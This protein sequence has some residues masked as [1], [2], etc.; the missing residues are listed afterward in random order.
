VVVEQTHDPAA[1]A[2][3]E[4]V[5]VAGTPPEDAAEQVFQAL[6]AQPAVG[7]A[8]LDADLRYVLVNARLAQLNGIP[9]EAHPGRTL[10]EVVPALAEAASAAFR[11]VLRTGRPMPELAFTAVLPAGATVE[12]HWLESAY[13]VRD[14]SG[15]PVAVAVL[16]WEVTDRVEA[17]RQRAQMLALLDL[18]ILRAP[19]G[20]ALLDRDLRYVR[21]NDN[22]AAANGLPVEA[23]LGRPLP[24]VI[25]DL[26]PQLVPMARHVLDTGRPL[27]DVELETPPRLPDRDRPQHW[28]V[29]YYPVFPSGTGDEPPDEPEGIGILVIDRTERVEAEQERARLLAAEREAAR[30]AQLAAD[31][32]ALLQRL[33]AALA[34]AMT[35]EHVAETMV[36]VAADAM[37]ASAATLALM[38]P[39]GDALRVV[40]TAGVGGDALG[41]DAEFAVADLPLLADVLRDRR[42]LYVASAVE[43]DERY[44]GMA[45]LAPDVEAWMNLL[46]VAHDEV[47]GMASFGWSAPRATDPDEIEVFASLALQCATALDRARLHA[48]ERAARAEAERGRERLALLARASDLLSA[49]LDE[50]EVLDRLVQLIIPEWSDWLVVLLPDGRGRLVPRVSV[51][52]DPTWAT[53]AG[54]AG[55]APLPVD[56]EVPASLVFRTG[57]QLY[58]DDVRPY[59]V[60]PGTP[61]AVAALAERMGPSPGLL[62][63][64]VVRG[65]VIGVLSLV[66]TSGRVGTL[67]RDLDLF[68]DLARRAGVA[69]D[70]ARLYG[71]RTRVA[72]RLQESLLPERLPVVPGVEVAVRYATAEEAVD[73]GGD[74]Y[75]LV[76]LAGGDHFVVVGDVAGRGVDA[77][78]V[79]GLARHTL[80][81]FAQERSPALALARLNEILHGQD[82]GERFVTAVA[83]RLTRTP[84]GLEA[85]LARAGH[86][87]PLLVRADGRVEIVLS[88]GALLGAFP[89]VLPEET[90]HELRAGDTLLLYTDGITESRHGDELFGE[91]RLVTAAAG[92]AGAGAEVLVET[93]LAAVE[94]FRTAPAEDDTALLALHV[95]A[96]DPR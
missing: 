7:F 62:V 33:T 29:S 94:A 47:L 3:L 37:G 14:R 61:P 18:L 59:L 58:T 95:L 66:D 44:P 86:T 46:L 69:L 26:A 13:P 82:A 45:G 96:E 5:A 21:I 91:E 67:G 79:T 51:H 55:S 75:D 57:Q 22:L 28:Q 25:P 52:A 32:Q 64:M 74:F 38:T 40:A 56:G 31:R 17:E 87:H 16:V 89:D 1:Q 10:H 80:R 39:D 9:I 23:H 20:I 83:G 71:Q 84:V 49:S 73:V 54:I 76:A 90:R 53:L 19:I 63:P 8:L 68:A 30:R 77:A 35:V 34:G 92:A 41:P 6:L 81:A 36:T 42:P 11:E 70:N 43:R 72:A 93:V 24:E 78:A 48:A 2:A 65:R 4:L 85:R 12:R 60:A 15:T 27:I 88:E 50:A